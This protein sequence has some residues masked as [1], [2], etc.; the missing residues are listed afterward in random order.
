[1]AIQELHHL[2]QGLTTATARDLH[3]MLGGPALLHLPGADPEPLFV[4]V[5]L[6]GDEDVGLLAIQSV[7]RA[8][9]GR[10]LPRALCVFFGNVEA[11]RHGLRYLDGQPDFNRVW[12]LAGSDGPAPT[13]H[14]AMAR[15]VYRRVAA[16]KPFAVIDLHNNT[17]RNPL[18]SCL[19]SQGPRGA[20]PRARKLAAL[21]SD[22]ALATR[23]IE[24][25]LCAAFGALCP[26]VSYECGEIGNPL[27]VQRA[28]GLVERVLGL[29]R[30]TLDEVDDSRL[31]TYETYATLKVAESASIGLDGAPGDLQIDSDIDLLNFRPLP[32]GFSLARVRPGLAAPALR[33][34]DEDD[35]EMNDVLYVDDTH[36][37]LR[38]EVIPAMLT[39]RETAIRK[40]CLGYLMRR[41]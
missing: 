20:D 17:G 10:P 24:G 29:D 1:M 14:H 38:A 37:R 34:L 6:H 22:I 4:S 19:N 2:P 25:T 18:Y 7:L 35:R 3:R 15:E 12:A 13:E 16:L 41:V 32:A 36:L 27:G 26:A 21:F 31:Q 28:A 5:L 40:T 23:T 33:V 11:A 9:E 8:F 30:R 39:P